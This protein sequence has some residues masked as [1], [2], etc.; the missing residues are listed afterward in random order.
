MQHS[1]HI[2]EL[3]TALAKA[4]GE[5]TGALK[6]SANP[7]FKSKYADLASCWDACRAP[8]SNNGLA[9]VQ[10]TE[11]GEPVT[12][13]W[14]KTDQKTGEVTSFKCNTYEQVIVTMLMHSSGQFIKSALALIPREVSEMGIGACITYGR[15]YGLA[16]M[17]GI[18]QV[19]QIESGDVKGGT[20]AYATSIKP[21]GGLGADVPD[22]VAFETAVGMRELLENDVEDRI[23]ALKVL[24]RHDM[25]NKNQDLYAAASQVLKPKERSDWKAYVAEAK[26]L[27]KEDRAVSNVGRRF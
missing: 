7:F 21:Q 6:D 5:I 19:D 16:A 9:V 4:Q 14:D 13:E 18:A 27:D 10:L 11:K 17:L 3:A 24:D 22:Q 12:V 26:K 8:L 2:N 20:Q 23:K 25:L 15:R 1:E